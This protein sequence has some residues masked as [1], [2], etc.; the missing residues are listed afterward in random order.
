[1]YSKEPINIRKLI[2]RDD[3][4]YSKITNQPYT[5]SVIYLYDD[6]EDI[7]GY[8]ELQGEGTLKNGKRDGEFNWYGYDGQLEEVITWKDGELIK[9]E[10]Y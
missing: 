6:D 7:Y 4:F 1:M 5:G 9:S 8:G 3:V 2:E 10:K